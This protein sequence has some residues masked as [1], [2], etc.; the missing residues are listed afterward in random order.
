MKLTNTGTMER[1]ER[2]AFVLAPP[3]PFLFPFSIERN[4]SIFYRRFTRKI[5]Q[6]LLL[7]SLQ[8]CRIL[9]MV[10]FLNNFNVYSARVFDFS[11]WIKRHLCFSNLKFSWFL[12]TE[13]RINLT[14]NVRSVS[15]VSRGERRDIASLYSFLNSTFDT[16]IIGWNNLISYNWFSTIDC[17][18]SKR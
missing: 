16:F 13:R 9:L 12:W 17:N 3:S 11:Y 5:L 7:L 6:R 4:G 10:V 18:R 14:L 8:F 15:T 1:K 2:P